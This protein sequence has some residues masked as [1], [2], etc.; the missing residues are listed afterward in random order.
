MY[1]GAK[2]ADPTVIAGG[3]DSDG[4]ILD[5]LMTDPDW[6]SYTDLLS[7]HGFGLAG[8]FIQMLRPQGMPLWNTETWYTSFSDKLVQWQ[9]FERARGAEKV[10]V[11]IL[12]N[13][14]TSGYRSGGRY[15][16]K[17]QANVP[18][19]IPHPA[20]VAY[21]AMAFQLE[22]MNFVGEASPNHLPYTMLFERK[23]PTTATHKAAMVFFGQG[24][25]PAETEWPLVGTVEGTAEVRELPTGV[26]GVFDQNGNA[27]QPASDGVMRVPFDTRPVYVTADNTDA[28]RA[29]VAALR[30]TKYDRPV[31]VGVIDP[32][33]STLDGATMSLRVTNA[34][35]QSLAVKLSITADGWAFAESSL[36]V[37]LDPGERRDVPLKIVHAG[38]FNN[39]RAE[40]KINV[41][42]ALGEFES[43]EPIEHRVIRRFTP[44]LD[45]TFDD[46]QTAGISPIVLTQTTG[47]NA[48]LQAAMPW[49]QLTSGE[50]V[51]GR[52]A[53][54]YDD[55]FLYVM[56]D[57]RTPKREQRPWDQ[58]RD[59]WYELHPGGY[60]YKVAP[61]WPF[62]GENVQIAIDAVPNP[63][64]LSDGPDGARSR[65][66]PQRQADYLFG[67]YE[68][69]QGTNQ[70]WLYRSPNE[71]MLPLHRY[72]FSPQEPKSNRLFSEAKVIVQYDEAAKSTRYEI[73]IPWASL[74]EI[75]PA[76]GATI[77]GLELKLT[78]SR[79]TGLASAAGRGAAK[80]DLSVFQP[81]WAGGFT[82]EIPWVLGD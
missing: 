77:A 24:A 57:I 78:T 74:P 68:T 16:P 38:A 47:P 8:H 14:F 61:R 76:P 72:P 17:D 54:S 46:W 65:R 75:K 51:A 2:A 52:Y 18:D 79:W 49:E 44:T 26:I 23:I 21:N 56:A 66:Y 70:A 69:Q 35:P 63:Q 30:V 22:G 5:N 64:H 10:N 59:D 43:T 48:A 80:S 67:F 4:N 71:K 39:G 28:L 81:H 25:T 60:A 41:A 53:L 29:F 73:A 12:G 1:R 82:A 31:Q 15:D 62:S 50:A 34:L 58:T 27:I 40:L 36:S 55:Q 20:A 45:G 42:T 32:T 7:T 13:V 19:L 37:T 33:A 3:N 11:L 9:M 6:Q